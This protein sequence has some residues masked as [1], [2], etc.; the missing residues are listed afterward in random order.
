MKK[1][2]LYKNKIL[3]L[4]YRVQLT[5]QIFRLWTNVARLKLKGID[6]DSSKQWGM[7]DNWIWHQKSYRFYA[8][9][10]TYWYNKFLRLESVA[11]SSSARVVKCADKTH[12]ERNPCIN[13][14]IVCIKT[15]KFNFFFN[16][17]IYI[18]L[19]VIIYVKFIKN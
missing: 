16:F 10:W 4:F 8:K 2:N 18:I 3:I 6:G 1:I 11:W 5:R 17:W 15:W 9:N 14:F 7:W 13:D 12:N 19:N